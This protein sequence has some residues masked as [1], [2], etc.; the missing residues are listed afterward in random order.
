[1]TST[2]MPGFTAEATL[3]TAAR[4][5][6]AIATAPDDLRADTLTLATAKN[7]NLEWIDCNDFPANSYCRECGNTG[8]DSAI[9]CPDGYCVVIDKTPRAGGTIWGLHVTAGGLRATRT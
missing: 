6:R 4:G 8:P 7:G 3:Y 5:Y 2:R 9:C 1:M